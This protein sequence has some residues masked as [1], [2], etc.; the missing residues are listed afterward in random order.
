VDQAFTGGS[1]DSSLESTPKLMADLKSS[2]SSIL[3]PLNQL[4]TALGT[5]DKLLDKIDKQLNNVAKS[6]KE[7]GKGL[8]G[9]STGGSTAGGIHNAGD[10]Q[11]STPPA[12]EAGTGGG[13]IRGFIN[14]VKSAPKGSWG[15]MGISAGLAAGSAIWGAIPNAS[16]AVIQRIAGQSAASF[17]GMNA[18]QVIDM[19]NRYGYAGGGI[20]G[21]YD[22]PM[23]AAQLA[24]SGYTPNSSTFGNIMS[25]V[26]GV[27]TMTGLS[28]PQAARAMA[29][30]NGMTGYAMGINIRNGNGGLRPINEITDQLY[31]RV[32][33]DR[34]PTAQNVAQVYGN[35]ALHQSVMNLAGGNQDMFNILAEGLKLQ[36]GNG[37]K[38]VKDMSSSAVMDKLG[39]AANDPRRSQFNLNASAAN[40][41]TAN[42]QQ[43]LGGY[44]AANNA[45]AAVNQGMAGLA[46]ILPPV[47]G[48][49]ASLKGMLETLPGAGNAGSALSGLAGGAIGGL[50]SMFGGALGMRRFGGMMS[51][52]ARG[53]SFAL[54]AAE[55]SGAGVPAVIGGR[56]ISSLVGKGAST[57]GKFAGRAGAAGLGINAAMTGS[58]DTGWDWNHAL[59]STA[60]G[61]GAGAA[62]GMGVGSVPGAVVGGIGGFLSYGAGRLWDVVNPGQGGEHFNSDVVQSGQGGVLS[63][64]GSAASSVINYA[65]SF[66]GAPYKLGGRSPETGWDCSYFTMNAFKRAG[67]NLPRTAQE[68]ANVGTDIPLTGTN[69]LGSAL[70]GDLLFFHYDHPNT[71]YINHVGIYIGGG[72]TVEAASKEKGTRIAGVDTRHLVKIKRVLGSKDGKSNGR[73]MQ[74][75]FQEI[76]KGTGAIAIPGM[77][78]G[79]TSVAGGV[80]GQEVSDMIAKL[81]G[82]GG[83]VGAGAALGQN[84]TSTAT[85]TRSNGTATPGSAPEVAGATSGASPLAMSGVS[86]A[87]NARDAFQYLS[88]HGFNQIASAGILGN[89]MAESGVNPASKQHGGGPGRGILQWET[90]GR[91]DKFLKWAGGR[92]K[93]NLQ[94]QLDFLIWE[95]EGGSHGT[96][97]KYG[98]NN[99]NSTPGEAAKYFHDREVHAGIVNMP[100]RIDFANAAFKTFGNGS[101]IPS[102][103]IGTKNVPEDQLALIHQGEMI[104]PS[105][106]AEVIR[107]ASSPGSK[108]GGGH[109]TVQVNLTITS[110]TND[111]EIKQLAYKIQSIWEEDSMSSKVGRF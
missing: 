109:S 60:V 72:R 48:G 103:D 101:K 54:A 9:V 49:L 92:P 102:Y 52:A 84:V 58:Q 74:Q 108:S 63:S 29:G 93:E 4:V 75:Q 105:K 41:L 59:T 94:T 89:L 19:S 32:F 69:R 18:R 77:F 20:T 82:S 65:S 96:G 66:V 6:A 55:Q 25:Q 71:P 106:I 107:A 44:N 45:T 21:A 46:Q 34:K 8:S 3:N 30:M 7:A 24:Y 5:F 98:L 39:W 57:L 80:E 37:G 42:S 17:S 26:G 23:A 90:P 111:A 2:F 22:M 33:Q 79:P 81:Y 14:D 95:T 36:Q 68:Q 31:N 61:A 88:Q 67:I 85:T 73:V 43:L 91:W 40:S 86:S 78:E 12:A 104:I 83:S 1:S 51:P 87:K 47:V 53:N 35:T 64:I 110:A 62:L 100:K 50:G 76:V 16:D 38:M 10:V 99:K 28:N 70:P 13:G 27:S 56:S 97:I 11:F 15:N